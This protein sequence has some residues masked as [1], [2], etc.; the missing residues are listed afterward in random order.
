GTGLRLCVELAVARRLSVYW[1]TWNR[2]IIGARPDVHRGN[3]ACGMARTS[4]R[5]LS[6]QYRSGNPAGLSF[7]L[8]DRTCQFWF[9]RMAMGARRLCYSGI[10]LLCD[11]LRHSS[12]SAV[13]G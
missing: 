4:G 5:I 1:R 8:P 3:F 9:D 7:E 6:V 10:S 2:R 13:A 11:A 12:K